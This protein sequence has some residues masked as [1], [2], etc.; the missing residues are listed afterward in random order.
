MLFSK[1]YDAFRVSIHHFRGRIFVFVVGV[2]I[3]SNSSLQ[4]LSHLLC[5][6]FS[7]ASL[8]LSLPCLMMLLH[9]LFLFTGVPV[10]NIKLSLP[11]LMKLVLTFDFFVLY[12]RVCTGARL[13]SPEKHY[14]LCRTFLVTR[15]SKFACPSQFFAVFILCSQT[16][17]TIEFPL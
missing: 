2:H 5:F 15:M 8:K 10:T 11:S 13:F 16:S 17:T 7:G 14:F 9:L 1:F 4:P 6:L 12:L 3:D